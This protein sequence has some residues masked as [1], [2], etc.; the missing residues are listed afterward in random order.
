MCITTSNKE[1]QKWIDNAI[2]GDEPC[3]ECRG[4]LKDLWSAAYN[5]SWLECDC[6][7]KYVYEKG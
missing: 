3:P 7:F 2:N 5:V 6:G 1:K 4:E